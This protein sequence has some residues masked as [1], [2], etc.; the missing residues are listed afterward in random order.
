M[1]N[2]SKA[3][4]EFYDPVDNVFVAVAE[5]CV[6]AVHAVVP[7]PL[8]EDGS[9][10]PNLITLGALGTGLAAARHIACD[11]RRARRRAAA[12]F[13][14]SYFLDCADGLYARKYNSTSRFGDALDH[15]C[16]VVKTIALAAALWYGSG[17]RPRQYIATHWKAVSLITVMLAF[18]VA[19]LGCVQR[20]QKCFD[21]SGAQRA[22]EPELLDALERFCPCP[23]EASCVLGRIGAGTYAAVAAYMIYNHHI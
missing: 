3:A 15:V 16:D 14:V 21:D 7:S 23:A 8:D 19:Q 1:S 17:L 4:T 22:C 6:D 18:A 12:L 10:V 11:G 20:A 9:Q 2:G 5:Y 13:L